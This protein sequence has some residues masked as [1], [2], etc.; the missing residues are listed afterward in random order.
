MY[1]ERLLASQRDS[2]LTNQE[3]LHFLTSIVVVACIRPARGPESNST[4]IR[5]GPTGCDSG[6]RTEAGQNVPH[7]KPE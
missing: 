5:V 4:E 3:S 6:T 1:C 7:E 2:S